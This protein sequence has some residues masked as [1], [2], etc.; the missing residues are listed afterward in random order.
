MG[1]LSPDA[2][3][4]RDLDGI[5]RVIEGGEMGQHETLGLVGPGRSWKT[6]AT[7]ASL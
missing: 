3:V 7:L 4:E 2:D 6:N 1:E 5:G